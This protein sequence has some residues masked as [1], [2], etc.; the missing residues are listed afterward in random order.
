M[1]RVAATIVLPLLLPTALYLGW[2]LLVQRSRGRG[3]ADGVRWA[4]LP[5]LWLAAT[6]VLLLALMLVVTI[7]FGSSQPGVYVPPR[8]EN[9]RV[10]PSHIEPNRSP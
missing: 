5:W 7:R 2:V 1:L 6:G 10:V 9:G 3:G 4:L 8:Y